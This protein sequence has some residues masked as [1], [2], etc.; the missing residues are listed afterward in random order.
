MKVK[1]MHTR[2]GFHPQSANYEGELHSIVVMGASFYGIIVDHRGHFTAEPLDVIVK[3]SE[4][5]WILEKK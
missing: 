3:I 1:V 5:K 4:K 2:K